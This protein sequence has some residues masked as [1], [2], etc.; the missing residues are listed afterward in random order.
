MNRLPDPDLHT[1]AEP[2]R[3]R[4]P[5]WARVDVLLVILALVVACERK[6][7]P[8]GQQALPPVAVKVASAVRKT[9]PLEIRAIGNV[10]ASATVSIRARVGGTLEEVHFAEGAEVEKGQLLFLIDPRSYEA[11]LKEAEAYLARDRAL[12]VRAEADLKRYGELVKQ[13]FVTQE[14]FDQARASA[15]SLS[16]T[17]A[18]DEAAVNNARLQLSYC[19]IY[20]PI[21]GRAGDLLVDPGNLIKANDDNNPMVVIHQVRPIEVRFSVPEEYLSRIRGRQAS[22]PLKVT[23]LPDETSSGAGIEGRL[24]FVNNT[25]DTSTGTVLLKASFP[26]EDGALWPGQ[27]VNVALV[28]GEQTDALVVP[29]RAIQTGQRGTY[30]FVVKDD[31]TVESRPVTVSRAVGEETVV[32]EGLSPGE[33]VVT[34]G[35]LRLAAG[36]RVE[37]KAEAAAEEAKP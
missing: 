9:M 10:V 15:A 22:G 19:S 34:D 36:A 8:T 33:T 31:H 13:D 16:A 27:F 30:V 6:A 7:E 12:L 25:V 5:T 32:A 24:T 20:A 29:S 1:T 17:V 4:V 26:N 21:S 23:A 35:Q 37:I 18:A 14:Q 28:L 11:D 3:A 2:A